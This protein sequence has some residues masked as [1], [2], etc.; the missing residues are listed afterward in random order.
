MTDPVVLDVIGVR[1]EVPAEGHRSVEDLYAAAARLAVER[2]P[3]LLFHAGA[4]E[5]D[6]AA[7][8]FPG[9][10]GTGKSTTVAACVRRGLGYLTDEMVAL[11]LDTG[12]VRG[13][14]RP[15]MLTPWALEAVGLPAVAGDASGKVAVTCAELGGTVVEA[16]LPVAHV[17]ALRR[18][19]AAT[20]L[21]PMSAGDALTLL[22]QSSFNHYRHGAAAWVAVTAL[23]E[24]VQGW[25]LDA[26]DVD[27]AAAAVAGLPYSRS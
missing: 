10:S 20:A 21:T 15:I 26:A 16:A 19:A 1:V 18:G 5:R 2:S 25:W 12:A 24:R 6:G 4:V 22:L 13:W 23:A 11:D 3:R 9:E 17:V 7:V 8:L 27:S 14:P